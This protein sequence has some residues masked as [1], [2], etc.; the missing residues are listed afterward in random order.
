VTQSKLPAALSRLIA[1]QVPNEKEAGMRVWLMYA[2]FK[3][4]TGAK[5]VPSALR[6]LSPFPGY[7]G[8]VWVD[9]KKVIGESAFQRSRDDISKRSLGLLVGLPVR[10]HRSLTRRVQPAMWR[11][12]EET[13]D[14]F[15]RFLPQ[16]S[17][18]IAV[19][20]RSYPQYTGNFL[21]A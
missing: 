1:L 13:V 10:D 5:H 3:R 18:M 4:T 14:G 12:I 6:V 7:M 9:M 19:W 2:D 17:L 11:D 15:A 20:L 8:S 16:L 21:V